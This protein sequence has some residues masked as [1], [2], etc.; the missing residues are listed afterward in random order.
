MLRLIVLYLP[1]QSKT[2]DSSAAK[3]QKRNGIIDEQI[4]KHVKILRGYMF[5]IHLQS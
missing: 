1:E 4:K 5:F 3:V 2:A